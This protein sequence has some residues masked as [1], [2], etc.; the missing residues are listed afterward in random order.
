MATTYAI[1]QGAQYMNA[2]LYTG[3]GG[4]YPTTTL[5]VTNGV[6]GT[7]F[8]PDFVWIKSRSNAYDH[9]LWDSVRGNTKY[10]QSNS[11]LAEQTSNQLPA[12]NSNGFTVANDGASIGTNGSGATFVGWQ[13]KAGGTAVSNT[14]GSVTSQ[15]SANTTSGFSVVKFTSGASAGFSVGH[16]LGVAPAMIIQKIT[17]DTGGWLVAH[18]NMS[19][20]G[21]TSGYLQLQSTNGFTSN[22]NVF[23]SVTS[24]TVTQGSVVSNNFAQIMYCW[25][26]IAGYS[27]FGSYTGNGSADGPFVY[28][29]F[30]PRWIMIKRTDSTSSWYI[31]DTSINP[32]NEEKVTLYPNLSNSEGTNANFLDGLSNGFKMR[33]AGLAV[34]G[35]TYI[36][37][38]F[39]ENPMKYANAR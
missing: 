18:Q 28:T 29:G 25:A 20:S 8:Q 11:T 9:F 13:W 37:A 23:T 31:C 5:S 12:F 6:A 19:A 30:R 10:V 22:S 4:T 32:Y 33:E 24:S 16:G 21:I 15:V 3:T 34:N 26:P 27:A 35:G 17:G 7:S 1:P 38:A 2:S 14:A 39:A 36:Y